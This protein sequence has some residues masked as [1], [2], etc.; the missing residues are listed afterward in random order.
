[1]GETQQEETALEA[2]VD[3]KEVRLPEAGAEL[4]EEPADVEDTLAV[5]VDEEEIRKEHIRRLK[6]EARL[7][8][9]GFEEEE[10]R[11]SKRANKG[12]P[13][14]KYMVDLIQSWAAKM[15][16]I[17]GRREHWA[18]SHQPWKRE[19]LRRTAPH[20]LGGKSA[21]QAVKIG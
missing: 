2:T 18:R 1:M 10:P 7:R 6:E 12:K 15:Y 9:D 4:A 13:A 20:Y 21:G 5:W 14:L 11:R 19:A 16:A 17:I 3:E 8:R